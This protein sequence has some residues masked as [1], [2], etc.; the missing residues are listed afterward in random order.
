MLQI[1]KLRVANIQVHINKHNQNNPI[2]NS[3]KYP[4]NLY[5]ID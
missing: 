3:F 5:T 4:Q 1:I 2:I